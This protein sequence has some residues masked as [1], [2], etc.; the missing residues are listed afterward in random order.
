M[1]TRINLYRPEFHP[2]FEWV[3]FPNLIAFTCASLFL[4][5]GVFAIV[6]YENYQQQAILTQLNEQTTQQK[7][8]IDTMTQALSVRAKDPALQR[9]LAN[10]E[11]S[12]S[13]K[14]LLL[15]ELESQ[16]QAQSQ[17]FSPLFTALASVNSDALWLEQFTVDNGTLSFT[18]QLSDA[19]ALPAWI[20][21]LQAQAYFSQQRFT[22]TSVK[23]T[24]NGLSFELSTKQDETQGAQL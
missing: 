2:R 11:A 13:N 24:A 17:G 1:K 16:E 21:A 15:D 18:G 3:S 8:A 12:L 4:S 6:Y 20:Q 10:L 19:A 23:R 9:K 14:R 7:A 22:H 5:L